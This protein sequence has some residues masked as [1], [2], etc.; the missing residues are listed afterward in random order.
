MKVKPL[1][2]FLFPFKTSHIFPLFSP[3][4]ILASVNDLN[5]KPNNVGHI[6]GFTP[7][8]VLPIEIFLLIS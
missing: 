2:C 1:I 6:I 4:I 8:P 5:S 3:S 7:F